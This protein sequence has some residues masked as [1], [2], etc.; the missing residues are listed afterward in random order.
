MPELPEVET[1]K[2][3]L[4]KEVLKRTINDV[5]V[6]YD[7]IIAYPSVLEFKKN[8]KG[9]TINDI[10][11]RGKFLMF[12]LDDYYLLSHLRMEGRYY[13]K[14]GEKLKHEH[15]RFILNDK[16]LRYIDTRKFGRMYLLPIKDVFNL[17]PLNELGLEPWDSN[18]TID[19]LK[20]KYKN[21]KLP[22]KTVL[23]DQSIIT[24]IGNIYDD[25]V[26]FLSKINPYKKACDL[27]DSDLNNIINNTKIVLEKAIKLGGT[28]IRSYE[29]SEGVHGLFQNELLVHG[30]DICPNCGS[31]LEKEHINGRGTYYCKKCQK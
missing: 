3:T 24:G 22:I 9:Q 30:K 13:I 21:K 15:V 27:R 11:R 10:E 6:Y 23:L 19:Y 5:I 7:N 29:S 31:I 17:K 25:E 20:N 2:E 12:K 18:L 8:I 1:V 16:E 26:L 28:T 4:K 14:N